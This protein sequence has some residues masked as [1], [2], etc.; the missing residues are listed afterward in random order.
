MSERPRTVS[1][2]LLPKLPVYYRLPREVWANTPDYRM[3]PNRP[4]D[5]EGL[6]TFLDQQPE[7]DGLIY[8]GEDITANE[9]WA[10]S[11]HDHL[12]G[13]KGGTTQGWHGVPHRDRPNWAMFLSEAAFE[14]AQVQRWRVPFRDSWVPKQLVDGILTLQP[15]KIGMAVLSSGYGD[16]YRA[17][18]RS[19]D[20]LG[21]TFANG[22]Y[23]AQASLYIFDLETRDL[24]VQD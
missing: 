12:W 19:I 1:A 22:P 11:V 5:V 14:R 6:R 17:G 7:G 2:V 23:T 16:W 3:A 13:R 9:A 8:L 21:K 24:W 4:S 18:E 20:F 15:E 10:F